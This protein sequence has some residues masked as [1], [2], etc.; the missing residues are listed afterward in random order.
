[1]ESNA[2]LA[3]DAAHG[4]ACVSIDAVAVKSGASLSAGE[5]VA[6]SIGALDMSG[7]VPYALT[8]DGNVLLAESATVTIPA[9]WKASQ[10]P[11]AIMSFSSGTLPKS[12]VVVLDNGKRLASRQVFVAGNE[13]RVNLHLGTCVVIR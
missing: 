13:V 5:G 1:M 7:D 4:S 11:F 2:S 8:I 9:A 10:E 12:P 3:I 6:V